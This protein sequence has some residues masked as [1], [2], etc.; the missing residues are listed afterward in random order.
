[1]ITSFRFLFFMKYIFIAL[2]SCFGHTAFSQTQFEGKINYDITSAEKNGN[3]QMTIFFG[4]P[5]IRLEALQANGK[6]ESEIIIINL[7]SGKIYTL[8]REDKKYKE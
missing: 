3:G 5:G 6:N 7:D 2:L 1:M 4:K 8:N